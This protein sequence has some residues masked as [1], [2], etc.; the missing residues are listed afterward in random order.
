MKLFESL[1]ENATAIALSS[2][3]KLYAF[4]NK[5]KI[6]KVHSVEDGKIVASFKIPKR[7]SKIAFSA[8]CKEIIVGDRFGDMNEYSIED[9]KA[10]VDKI[11]PESEESDKKLLLGHVSLL[12]DFCVSP[13][14]KTIAS[15]DR[16]EKVRL[17]QFPKTYVIKGFC[18]GH[19]SFVSAICFPPTDSTRLISGGKDEFI[20]LWNLQNGYEI[21]SELNIKN[22]I[23][24]NEFSFVSRIVPLHDDCFIATFHNLD[25]VLFLN[26]RDDRLQIIKE[27][28]LP[29]AVLGVSVLQS[30]T[31]IIHLLNQE[32]HQTLHKLRYNQDGNIES[33]VMSD[34]S[35]ED[36]SSDLRTTYQ[37]I[38]RELKKPES[39][40]AEDGDRVENRKKTKL[41]K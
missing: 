12:T 30:G 27:T 28:E 22:Y 8:S 39:F 25:K 20:Y 33:Q 10:L 38:E 21:V 18:L 4:V 41:N 24:Q 34:I 16:D 6:M 35:L 1:N 2:D 40:E 7:P 3:E 15:A 17:T 11:M 14:G 32:N 13:D 31:I 36:Y 29:G 9:G 19:K 26:L 5:D 23:D 37:N